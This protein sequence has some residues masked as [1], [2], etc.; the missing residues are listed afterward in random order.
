[1][2][3]AVLETLPNGLRLV[4]AK[5]DHVQSA[6]FGLFVASGSRHEPAELAGISHFIEHMLFKGT[7][8]RSALEITQAIEGRGGNFNASTSESSTCFYAHVP[9]NCI[10]TAVDIISDMYLN[11]AIPPDEFE[12]E[13]MV[14]LEEIKMYSDEPDSV[15]SENLSSALFPSNALGQPIAGGPETLMKMK[16]KTL[17][18]YIRRCYVPSATVA[19]VT[20]NFDPAAVWRAVVNTL[21]RLAPGTPPGFKRVGRRPLPVREIRAERDVQQVQLALGYRTSFG[22]HAHSRIKYAATV[23]DCLMGRTMSSRLFQS[24]REKRGLSYDIHSQ[25]QLF[26]DVGGWA[27]FAGIDAGNLDRTLKAIDVELD[28]IRTKPPSVAELRRAQEFLVGNFRIG[29]ESQRARMFGYGNCVQTYGELRSFE[30][31]TAEI[32]AVTRDDILEVANRI[33]R[34]EFRSV[35][36]VTPRELGI[37]N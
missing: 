8:R 37:R 30:S 11:A 29:L 24:I 18:D 14:V 12:R 36:L 23:F 2:N 35:S 13:R 6:C 34:P 7:R 32:E 27:V 1:M 9:G 10:L 3:D 31:V 26:D 33:I 5:D 15:A 28:R 17:R 20:G 22:I 21:G 16:P 4:L 25:L 19:V